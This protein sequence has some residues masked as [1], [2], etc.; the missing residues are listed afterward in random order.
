MDRYYVQTPFILEF[1]IVYSVSKQESLSRVQVLGL[2][3]TK[4]STSKE[5]K[6]GTDIR[7]GCTLQTYHLSID[8]T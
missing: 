8:A 5:A 1:S 7:V 4:L 2:W 6:Q 3:K